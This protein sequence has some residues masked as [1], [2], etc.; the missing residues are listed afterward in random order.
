[1]LHLVH[2]ADVFQICKVLLP[3]LFPS[4][5]VS[6]CLGLWNL[7]V[8]CAPLQRYSATLRTIKSKPFTMTLNGGY[9][10]F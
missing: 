8:C 9:N 2:S 5:C 3:V 1:M 10:A 4:V 6:V 7:L